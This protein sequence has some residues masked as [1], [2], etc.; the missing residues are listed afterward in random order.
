MW[1]LGLIWIVGCA[2]KEKADFAKQVNKYKN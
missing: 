1:V 2:L